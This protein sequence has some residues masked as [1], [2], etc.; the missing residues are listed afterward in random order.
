[1]AV[2]GSVWYLVWTHHMTC[3][4]IFDRIPIAGLI[5]YGEAFPALSERERP[6]GRVFPSRVEVEPPPRRGHG[7]AHHPQE[8]P[9]PQELAQL[10]RH[11]HHVLH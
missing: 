6:S 2:N 7:P 5:H 3:T 1:M 9:R 4:L 10:V 11:G 8:D